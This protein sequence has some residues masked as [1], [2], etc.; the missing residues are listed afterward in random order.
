MKQQRNP[1]AERAAERLRAEFSSWATCI[2]VHQGKLEF[3]VPAP[4]GSKAGH[5]VV[6]NDRDTLWVRFSP[7]YMCYLVDDEDEMVS[8]VKQLIRDEAIFRVVT[9][10]GEWVESTLVKPQQQ[11]A[12]RTSETVKLVSWTGRLDR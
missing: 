6:F 2:D 5:L 11:P 1:I 10:D 4:K 3:S 7:P 8:I 9:K 12:P